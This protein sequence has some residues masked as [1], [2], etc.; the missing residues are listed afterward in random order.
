MRFTHQSVLTA[1]LAALTAIH[2]NAQHGA[3]MT[4]QG[5]SAPV[6]AQP[7]APRPAVPVTSYVHPGSQIQNLGGRPYPI[8]TDIPPPLGLNPPAAS[9]TGISPGAFKSPHY[10]SFGG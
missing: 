5:R 2:L 8:R 10:G 7:A 3:G 1:I 6:R 9:Y 4:A